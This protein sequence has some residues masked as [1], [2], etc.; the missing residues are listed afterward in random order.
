MKL[1]VC[2]GVERVV[3]EEFVCVTEVV[4]ALELSCCFLAV[5]SEGCAVRYC[6]LEV[7]ELLECVV[8]LGLRVELD[9]GS[10]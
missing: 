7:P 9:I 2:V 10:L 5:E 3:C 4:V 8:A 1:Y 6:W